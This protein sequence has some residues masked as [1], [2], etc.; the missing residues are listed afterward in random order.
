MKKTIIAVC[1]ALSGVAAFAGSI[2]STLSQREVRDPKKLETI[3]E[4]NFAEI[5][6]RTDGTTAIDGSFT[7]ITNSGVTDLNGAT[8]VTNLTADD[9]STVDFDNSTLSVT[10]G[11]VALNGATVSGSVTASGA[12]AFGST[13]TLTANAL[14]VTNSQPVTISRGAYTLTGIGQADNFTNTITLT[15][16]AAAGELVFLTVA[17]AS[18]NLVSI[19]DSG[20]V[21]ASGAILLDGNDSALLIA[22]D[23]STWCLV[24]ESDN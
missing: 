3:L 15:A 16:P 21:A 19:A 20:T 8:T 12:W 11:T 7:S 10:N 9:G 17:T 1:V 4:A 5:D 18:S 2:Q 24:S 6:N 14:N 13:F 23:G 22:V